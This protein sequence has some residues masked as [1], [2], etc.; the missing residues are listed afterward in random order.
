MEIRDAFAAQVLRLAIPAFG[1][2]VAPALFL[3]VDAAVVGTLGTPQLAGLGAGGTV[4]SAVLALGFFLA[5]STTATVARRFGAGQRD[6]AIADGANAIT[7]GFVLGTVAAVTLW[8]GADTL[9]ELFGASANVTPHAV[10]W[11]RG[12]VWGMP[13]ALAAMATIGLFRGFQDTRTTLVVTLIQ[14]VTNTLL[15]VTFV[16][17]LDLGTFGSGLA[18]AIA[19]WVGLVSYLVVLEKLAH[20]VGAPLRPTGVRAVLTTFRVGLPLLWRSIALRGVLIGATV[21][22]SH[23]GDAEL[24]AYYVSFTVWYTLS[25]ALDAL[26]I[27]AQAMLGER[28]GAAVGD[29]VRVMMRR[30]MRWSVGLGVLLGI[31]TIAL[32]PVLPYAFGSDPEVHGLVIAALVAVGL[33]QPLS[34]VVFLLDGV[35]IGSGDAK[36]LAFVQTAAFIGFLP[37]AWAVVHWEAGILALWGAMVWFLTI[38]GI[39]LVARART[40]A[41][42][43]EGATR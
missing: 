23:L 27:A 22:A 18:T 40:D 20:Q 33:H 9:V 38:R 5:Y 24:A 21:V 16:L 39:L 41:W 15:C 6:R 28:L 19:E 25:L 42:I 32:S 37:V 8:F 3:L 43:V 1:A 14:V 4:F 36:Y 29:D 11:L 30:L 12:V 31:G 26:A 13:A 10:D 2:L 17:V 34:A 7:L 35:L